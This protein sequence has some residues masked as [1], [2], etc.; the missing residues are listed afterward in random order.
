MESVSITHIL[1]DA[2]PAG[3]DLLS[4]S[5]PLAGLK[6]QISLLNPT[7]TANT[8]TAHNKICRVQKGPLCLTLCSH[9]G[10]YILGCFLQSSMKMYLVFF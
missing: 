7:P 3:D 8:Q 6:S 5:S 1:S 2:I 10:S 9:F 4:V